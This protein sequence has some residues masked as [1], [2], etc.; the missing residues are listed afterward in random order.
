MLS[1]SH[2]VVQFGKGS[3]AQRAV[4]FGIASQVEFTDGLGPAPRSTASH[5]A[6]EAFVLSSTFKHPTRRDMI[7]LGSSHWLGQRAKST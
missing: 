2:A 3:V 6:D 5:I 4:H 7:E 1:V